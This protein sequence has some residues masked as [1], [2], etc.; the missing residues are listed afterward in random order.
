[1]GG[2]GATWGGRVV[3]RRNLRPMGQGYHLG[4]VVMPRR[5]LRPNIAGW[6]GRG[7]TLGWGGLSALERNLPD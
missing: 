4:V 5:D 2:R 1:M 6:E 7:A 3:P